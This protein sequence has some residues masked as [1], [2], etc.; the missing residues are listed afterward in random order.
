MNFNPR[1]SSFSFGAHEQDFATFINIFT[2][3]TVLQNNVFA[4]SVFFNN[5]EVLSSEIILSKGPVRVVPRHFNYTLYKFL[6]N[7][8]HI[9]GV[10]LNTSISVTMKRH[11]S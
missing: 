10:A 9:D 5:L 3:N 4:S 6:H 7:D 2:N 11:S 8:V 1:L